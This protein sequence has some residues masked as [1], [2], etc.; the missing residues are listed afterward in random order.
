MRIAVLI[1]AGGS[2]SRYLGHGGQ[3]PKLEEDLAG[4]SVLSRAVELFTKRHETDSIVVA[5]P[6]E[7]AADEL[8]RFRLRHADQLAFHG[9]TLVPGGETR[10]ASVRAM[11]AHVPDSATHV[12]VHDA[13]RPLADDALLDRLYD[14]A[15]THD[16]V[17]PAV[18]VADTLKRTRP[19]AA[20]RPDDPLDDILGDAGKVNAELDEVVETVSRE[21][22]V[23]VQTPQ[24][25]ERAL[26]ARAHEAGGEAT[27]DAA[28]VE[29]L[30]A[31]VVVVAGDV[32]NLKITVPGD[33]AVAQAVM[34]RRA[35]G[36]A[37]DRATHKRF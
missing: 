25:Y 22:L 15:H 10:S 32:T 19:A 20:A 28:L 36:G 3:R 18:A 24:V 17:I 27:D 1:A 7:S 6:P 9:V 29:S 16:A 13:A 30:G 2:S 4:R 11:L 33:L 14:A 12:A 35:A 31:R 21:H 8:E 37:A 5:G 23:A 26:F 34:K